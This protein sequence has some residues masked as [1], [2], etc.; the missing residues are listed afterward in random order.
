[1]SREPE[2][3]GAALFGDPC[4]QCGFGW[5]LA[6]A[7]AVRW[8]ADLGDRFASATATARGAERRPS[9]GWSVA[10]Y[11]CHVGDNLRQWAER[12]QASR[13]ASQSTVDSYDPDILAD[14]RGYAATPLTVALWS[15]GLAADS[16]VDVMTLALSENVEVHHRT[17]GR[18]RAEDI[19]RNNCHD[20]FHH[21]WDVS[22]ILTATAD[23]QQLKRFAGNGHGR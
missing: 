15:A 14:A 21:L 23:G 1:M 2:P 11:V 17:R 12:I 13:L 8:V 3:W 4:R 7:E 9:G 5:G 22:S 19:A 20:A 6:P 16:W 10:E 18:Q